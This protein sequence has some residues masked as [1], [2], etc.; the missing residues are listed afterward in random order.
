M[1]VLQF[2]QPGTISRYNI[3]NYCLVFISYVI[4]YFWILQVVLSFLLVCCCTLFFQLLIQR[5]SKIF[6]VFFSSHITLNAESMRLLLGFMDIQK[7][8]LVLIGLIQAALLF[9]NNW[10]LQWVFFDTLFKNK[11]RLMYEV[12]TQIL[13]ALLCLFQTVKFL[14]MLNLNLILIVAFIRTWFVI[15]AVILIF[16]RFI[17]TNLFLYIHLS[18]L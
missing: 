5:I 14:I 11:I 15:I 13:I 3:R 17:Q 6:F 7:V 12:S 16:T 18:L 4:F 1:I 8:V 9:L 10:L 2:V